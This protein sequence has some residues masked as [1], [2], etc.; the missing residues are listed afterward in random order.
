MLQQLNITPQEAQELFPKGLRLY[1]AVH[2]ISNPIEALKKWLEGKISTPYDY[3]R[4]EIL[5]RLRK[6]Q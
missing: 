3:K 1:F 6:E 5:E 2:N 4:D